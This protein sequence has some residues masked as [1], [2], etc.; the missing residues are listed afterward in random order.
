MKQNRFCLLISIPVLVLI[1]GAVLYEINWISNS[2]EFLTY[3]AL[4][5]G[6]C[7]KLDF[8]NK[9]IILF[10]GFS[11][12]ASFF[13]FF[14]DEVMIYYIVLVLQMLSYLFL[15]TEAWRHTKRETGNKFMLIFFFLMII[16]NVYFVFDHFQVLKGHIT[17]FAEFGLYS[18]YYMT[19]LVL[20]I[21]GLVYYLNSYSRKSV[22]FVILVM[23]IVVSGILRDM[24]LYYFPDTSVLLLQSFLHFAGI[25]LAFRFYTTQEKKLKLMDLV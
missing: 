5:F 10:L 23:S 24:A 3:L 11:I 19:L 13:K 12:S 21:V 6:F 15:I 17:G 16:A 7:S 1:L 9:N 22:Y 8:S 18:M 25:L 4:T 2:A 14:E 20:S